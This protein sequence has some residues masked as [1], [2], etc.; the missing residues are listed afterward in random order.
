MVSIALVLAK[1]INRTRLVLGNERISV[2][3]GEEAGK[4]T[5]HLKALHY[6]VVFQASGDV[7]QY[8]FF[9]LEDLF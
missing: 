2:K 1:A 8:Q 4:A 7:F 3:N 5:R 9:S 6:K